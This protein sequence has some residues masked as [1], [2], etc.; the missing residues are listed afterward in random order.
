MSSHRS[1]RWPARGLI[2]ALAALIAG[3][4]P[5]QAAPWSAN[6]TQFANEFFARQWDAADAAVARGQTSRSWTWGPGP[7]F[8]YMEFYQQARNGLRQVQY[9]DKARMELVPGT[10][11]PRTSVTNGLLPVELI[12]GRVK[13]GDGIGDDQNDQRESPDIPVAGDP[14]VQN[15]D[16]P[17][18]ATFRRYATVDNGYRNDRQVGLRARW[19]LNKDGSQLLRE[20]LAAIP[21]A[22][23]VR[24]EDVTGHNVSRVFDDFISKSPVNGLATFGLAITDPWWVRARVGGVEKDILVQ[25]F[26][27]RVLT[28]TPTNP[29]AFQ[30]EMGNVGQHYFQWRYPQLGQPWTSTELPLPITFASNR[31]GGAFQFYQMDANGNL[32]Q[33]LYRLESEELPYSILRSWDPAYVRVVGSLRQTA[34]L[35]QLALFSPRLNEFTMPFASNARD[36][37]PAISPDGAKIVFVSD[38]DGQPDLYLINLGGRLTAPLVRLTAS[39]GCSSSHPSWLP[40]GSGIVYESN[41]QGGNFEIYRGTLRYTQDKRDELR[42]AGMISP[43]A[44]GVT[45]LTSSTQDDRYPRVSPDGSAIAFTAW[46]DGNPEIYLMS[47]A[48][49]RQTRLTNSASVDQGA[50]WSPDGGRLVFNSNRDGDFEIFSM[51]VDGSRQLQLTNND[52]DDAYQVWAQ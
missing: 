28:F 6:R 36:T 52:A 11:I 2:V 5:A 40:D 9:F 41:C 25:I 48:G 20:D 18:Y 37:Q 27:R 43:G 32:Q 10:S 1:S 21:D 3:A 35:P 13:L 51:N 23:F 12:S 8:D 14:R 45:R 4:L 47:G 38:R 50:S 49:E 19:Q 15:P 44:E 17:T 31:D 26:E 33:P 16:G 30:V 7:W 29:A 39:P 46:R 24:Y 42:V 34:A 22:E